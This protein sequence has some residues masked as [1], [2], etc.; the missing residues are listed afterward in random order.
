MSFLYPLLLAG[1]VAVA[2]PIVLHMIRRHTRKRVTFSSLMFLR[3]TAPRLRNRSSLEHI[4]L[5]ILRCLIL[6]LLAF[7]FARPFLPRP[8][9]VGKTQPGRRIV[10]LVDTSASMRR[11][12][13][14]EQAIEEAKSVLNETGPSDRACVMIFDQNTQTLVGFEQWTAMDPSQRAPVAL[15]SLSEVAPGWGSTNLGQA[16]VAA[17]ETVEDDETNDGQQATGPRRVVLIGDLQRGSS[18]EALHAYEWPERTELAVKTIP[19]ESRTNASLQLVASRDP[20]ASARQSDLPSIRVTNSADATRD[21]FQLH[22]DDGSAGVAHQKTDVYVPPGRSIVIQ[23]PAKPDSSAATKLVLTGDDHDFDNALH[24][25]PPLEQLMNILYIGGDDP[26][27]T[28]AMLYYVRQVF[29]PRSASP[30]RVVPRSSGEVL[31]ASEIAAANL[32]VV[33]DVTAQANIAPL[34]QYLD[35]GRT[36]LLVMGSAETAATLSGLAGIDK[37]EC[38]EAEVG[39]YA[40]LDSIDFKHP[41]LA[42]FSDPRFGDFT[43]I[44]FWRYR[45]VNVADSPQMRMLARFDS[46][47]PAWFEVAV[48]KGS[49]LVWTSG[50]HPS[51]SDL[52][53]S[54]KFVPLLYSVLE[55]GGTLAERQLQYFVGD[56]VSMPARVSSGAAGPRIR[57]PD[58]SAV[59]LETDRQAFTQADLPG[60]Y[61]MESPAGSRAFAINLPP[62]ESRTEPMDIEDIERLGISLEPVSDIA[63][64]AAGQ[65]TRH[66][67]FAQMESE[68]KLWRWVLVAALA[69]L[70]IEIW[71]GGWL[72]RPNPGSEGEQP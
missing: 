37:L 26:N 31:T 52:A 4:P 2:L 58:N 63:P 3:T 44:H 70:V 55:H 60:I 1:V 69:M 39:R 16:L 13:M 6:C 62:G 30:S 29:G 54:S 10:L 15:R 20:L 7:A 32:V 67:S 35:S 56:P 19:C 47:A 64:A 49:L 23:A 11:A 43:R 53:L 61:T 57:K 68:Q 25:A 72:T 8:T 36:I 5:L 71:L 14:W 46:G 33:A 22:W 17:A 65:A 59:S 24:I 27:D 12:G 51:D 9:A 28:K 66:S 38:R 50:W 42:P 48:G 41:L 40:M 45:R 18:I 34:R 21:R